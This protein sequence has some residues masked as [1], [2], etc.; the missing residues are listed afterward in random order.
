MVR[1]ASRSKYT[2]HFGAKQ[3][4]KLERQALKLAA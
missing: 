3:A 1:K 4:K 2:P